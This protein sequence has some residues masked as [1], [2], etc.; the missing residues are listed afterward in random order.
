MFDTM[1]VTKTVGALCGTLLLFLLANWAAATV[2]EA[3]SPE[4]GEEHAM[5]YPIEADEGGRSDDATDDGPDFATLLAAADL[6]KGE[7][8]FSKC[9]A[10]HK[11]ED[12]ANG[13][14]PH[15]YAVVGRDVGSVG[16]FSYSGVL[17]DLQGD[18][19][20]EALDRFLESPKAYANGTKMSFSGLRKP[21]DR[22]NVIAFLATIGG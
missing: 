17:V 2:Y 13:T 5:A 19:S 18:W 3:G 21:E 8:I 15:L 14:G 16:E 4:H 10:C 1:T 9:K 20:P 22:A 6:G 11:L 12:G 7:K